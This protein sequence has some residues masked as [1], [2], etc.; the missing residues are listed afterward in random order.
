MESII[1]TIPH[2]VYNSDKYADSKNCYLAQ[3]LRRLGY[4]KVLVGPF[5]ICHI[6]DKTYTTDKFDNRLVEYHFNRG[7][8]IVVELF[9]HERN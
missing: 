5:G 3:A 2:E 1:V 4:D 9:A 7:E 6:G 8:D